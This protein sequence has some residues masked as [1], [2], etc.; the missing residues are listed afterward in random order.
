MTRKILRQ[1]QIAG[2]VI[3]QTGSRMAE[4]MKARRSLRP[5]NTEPVEN[6]V[7][8]I[9]PKKV[10]IQ[11]VSVGLSKDEISRSVVQRLSFRE[12]MSK[13]LSVHLYFGSK[14]EG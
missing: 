10:L 9:F 12:I 5:W 14:H 3:D 7:E 13:C 11:G 1:F 2:P 6:R 8:H 4:T